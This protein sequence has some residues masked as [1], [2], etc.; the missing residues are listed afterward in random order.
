MVV[1][2]TP[3]IS[4]ADL[5]DFLHRAGELDDDDL[6]LVAVDSACEELRRLTGQ[7]FNEGETT[8]LLD[9]SNTRSLILPQAPVSEIASVKVNDELVDA[10]DYVVTDGG[11]LRRVKV[12]GTALSSWSTGWPWGAMNVEVAYSHG[13]DEVPRDLRMLALTLAGRI[14]EQGIVKQETVGGSTS[15]FSVDGPLDLTRTEERIVRRYT[16]KKAPAVST[17]TGS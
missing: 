11:V 3:F 10:G 2:T 14:Y 7:N 5:G 1:D 17:E 12:N 6:A 8:V 15:T 13:F 9:G 4:R 16:L